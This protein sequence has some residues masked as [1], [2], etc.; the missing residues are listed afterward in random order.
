MFN[1]CRHISKLHPFI[2][3]KN[4]IR[5]SSFLLSFRNMSSN[6]LNTSDSGSTDLNLNAAEKLEKHCFARFDD[7]EKSPQDVREYRGL[8]LQN[9]MKVLLISD[10]NTDL[11]AAALSVQVGHMSDPDYLPGL[12]HFCEHML[13]LGTE[14]YPD[15]NGYT[16]YLSQNGGSSNAATYSLM[17]KYHFNVAPDKLDGALDRFAQFFIAPLFTSSATDREINAVMYTY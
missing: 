5:S 14:K 8:H 6:Y 10:I 17:T 13:F 1:I 7:I 16:T 2:K 3:K 15:E 9:G 11:S 12:A 4:N